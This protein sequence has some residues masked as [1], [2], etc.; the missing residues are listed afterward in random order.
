MRAAT[1]HEDIDGRA[2]DLL[3]RGD[4]RGALTILMNGYGTDIFRFCYS[5]LKHRQDTED[6][7]QMVFVQAYE[8][9]GGADRQSY[10]AWLISIAHNRC[11]DRLRERSCLN[12]RIEHCEHLPEVP[13]PG[14][15]SEDRLIKDSDAGK[16]EEC[17][18][19]LDP[20]VRIAI[21][22]R[23]Q[24]GFTF[25]E[26]ARICRTAAATLQAKVS[27]AMPVL[28]SALRRKKVQP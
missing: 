26:M 12:R 1:R 16:L 4:R 21:I 11:I 14:I 9:L 8:A 18:G 15:S 27:R 20:E 17:L 7:H 25:P 5:I 6:V 10:R 23:Y 28:L 24:E 2:R 19:E 22:L 13:D 3:A